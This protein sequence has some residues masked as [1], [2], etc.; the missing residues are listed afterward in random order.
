[1]RSSRDAPAT[2]RTRRKRRRPTSEPACASLLLS[3]LPCRR[4]ADPA[5]EFFFFGRDAKRFGNLDAGF[6]FGA[7]RFGDPRLGVGLRIVDRE[8][9]IDGVAIDAPVSLDRPHLIAVRLALRAEPRLVI[10]P[11]RLDDKR[12]AF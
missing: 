5:V 9:E 3:R 6:Q 4:L 10:E 8:A 11:D 7:S 2:R 12:V 1:M